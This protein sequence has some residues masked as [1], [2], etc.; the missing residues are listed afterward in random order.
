MTITRRTFLMLSVC[1]ATS[2]VLANEAW[3]AEPALA[4]SD[5][6]ARKLGYRALATTV[7]RKQFPSY[8]PGQKCGTCSL[9]QAADDKWG[10]CMLFSGKRVAEAGW[11]SS[12]ST[13]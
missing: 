5:E 7:D 3:A 8:V 2:V 13:M 10:D 9:F 6:A 11:C 4:E 12:Y 1:S